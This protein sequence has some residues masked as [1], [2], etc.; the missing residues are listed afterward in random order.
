MNITQEQFETFAHQGYN[1]IP[2][3]YE[4][5][6]DL[7]TPVSVYLK[8]ANQPYTYLLE[9][10]T[11]G[12]KWARYSFIGLPCHTIIRVKQG[13][14]ITVHCDKQLIEKL[15]SSD[16][17]NWIEQ[18]QK[19]LHSPQLK[20][21]PRFNGGLVGYFGYDTIRYI[22]PRLK[23]CE[24]P[25]PLNNPDI[26]LMESNDFIAFDN[27]SNKAYL[28]MQID[29][30]KENFKTAQ[31]RLKETAERLHHAQVTVP[32]YHETKNSEFNTNTTKVEYEK[33]VNRAIQYF[34]DG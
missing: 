1:R 28:I 21:F 27:I 23:N 14:E 11:G 8:L 12:E 34:I 25:D 5:L 4:F 30:E 24:L 22:E 18:Y 32:T 16:P 15:T 10:V 6:A 33:A 17:L 13:G 19:R 2:V 9:S 31:K 20:N 7:E 29:P 3:V 26:L